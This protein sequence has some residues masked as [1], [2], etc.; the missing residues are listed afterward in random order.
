MSAPAIE[1]SR[2][3]L[4]LGGRPLFRDLS[5]RVER[6]ERLA[7]VGDNGV[8][9]STLLDLMVGVRRPDGGRVS[10]LGRRPPSSAVGL[11]PQDLG[12]SLLPWFD[13]RD[14]VLLPLRARRAS[15]DEQRRRLEEIVARIDPQ[16][17]VDLDALPET[18]SGGQRQ[19]VA[20]MRALVAAPAVLVCDEPLSAIDA[21]SRAR[22]REVL[23]SVVGA[24]DGPALILVTHDPADHRGLAD[25][26]VRLSGRPAILSPLETEAA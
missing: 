2:V 14:N 18:L 12:A 24:A 16:G 10:V 21:G 9:K 15:R 6:G 1:L 26:V 23:A 7:V 5:L 11:V 8:G 4:A 17:T 3:S 22:L 13:V 19:L 20:L 25:R